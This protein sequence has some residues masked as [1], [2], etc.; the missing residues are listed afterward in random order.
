MRIEL[1]RLYPMTHDWKDQNTESHSTIYKHLLGSMNIMNTLIQRQQSQIMMAY[2]M[3]T[4]LALGTLVLH[5]VVFTMLMHSSKIGTI[6]LLVVTAI[7]GAYT[8]KMVL[9]LSRLWAWL[10]VVSKEQKNH[11]QDKQTTTGGKES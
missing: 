6:L 9:T 11:G 3:L 2:R 7:S 1:K 4:T 5:L 10:Q 8:L